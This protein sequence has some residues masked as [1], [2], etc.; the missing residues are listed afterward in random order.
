MILRK[1]EELLNPV[2]E[3]W[4]GMKYNDTIAKSGMNL[5]LA[6]KKVIVEYNDNINEMLLHSLGKYEN[7]NV[8]ILFGKTKTESFQ[9]YTNVYK[10]DYI[11][12]G[13]KEFILSKK[14]IIKL[15]Y[16]L[17]FLNIVIKS[18]SHFLDYIKYYYPFISKV[19]E[20]SE[21]SVNVLFVCKKDA[22][23]PFPQSISEKDYYIFVPKCSEE[24]W[25]TGTLFYSNKTAEFI[26]LQNFD[27]FLTKENEKS[28]EMFLK[29]RAWLVNNVP[30]EKQASF[31]LFSSVVLYLIGN[32]GMNDLD[33][34]VHHVDEDI[35]MKLEEFHTNSEYEFMEFRVKGTDNWPH[36]WDGWLD[37]WAEKCGA[38]YF[39]E[40]LG[41]PKYHFYFL[42]VK[43][44][45]L[46]CDIQRRIARNR[47]RATADL[48]ALRKRY[49]IN[50]RVPAPD[51]ISYE[52][53]SVSGK[54]EDEIREMLAK[55]LESE[56]DAKNREIKMVVKNDI[57]RFLETVQWALS[58]RY[59]M[60]FSI[61]EI[62]HEL[63]MPIT[64]RI[65]ISIK[66]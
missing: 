16:Q 40:I 37:E 3:K 65:K 38:K 4:K 28:K 1:F 31:M 9:T 49:K 51:K 17:V 6:N 46:D 53:E 56:Y 43:I 57:G 23:K 54:N 19:E 39:E 59:K 2:I 26:E 11:L 61:D 42:G 13:I 22:G 62:K 55:N 64:N 44:I 21:I 35:Q 8:F 33:L 5:S 10:N 66:R 60:T 47:P 36:Y 7:L 58:E 18:K 15:L 14:S 63:H 30:L 24:K 34:Y 52:Y 45:S 12:W 27:F 41:N 48:I 25:I 20:D 29:Y 32:R 50:I